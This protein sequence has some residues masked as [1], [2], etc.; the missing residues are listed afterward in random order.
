MIHEA[1]GTVTTGVSVTSVAQVVRDPSFASR[2]LTESVL[3]AVRLVATGVLGAVSHIHGLWVEFYF[4][5]EKKSAYGHLGDIAYRD[6]PDMM[7][8]VA[9]TGIMNERLESGDALDRYNQDPPT[10]YLLGDDEIPED[11]RVKILVR[12]N[13]HLW[14]QV[15]NVRV[16]YG[17]DDAIYKVLSLMP[18]AS[19]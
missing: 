4:P 5:V 19:R 6:V 17:V 12:D 10:L 16:L 15:D 3:R 18:V 1:E 13:H 9:V 7:K 8:R 11:T 2:N 14:F